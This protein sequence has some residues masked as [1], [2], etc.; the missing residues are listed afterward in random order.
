MHTVLSR[1]AK[2]HTVLSR[3]KGHAHSTIKGHTVLSRAKGHAHSTIKGQGA[4]YY[5][6]RGFQVVT[7]LLSAVNHGHLIHT[8]GC[9]DH[10]N[11]VCWLKS[12]VVHIP[13][14]IV[15]SP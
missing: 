6:Y 10:P 5:L 14:G 4:R 12:L 7:Q 3:A 13:V 2:V 11:T 1:G 15:A 9:V 8:L